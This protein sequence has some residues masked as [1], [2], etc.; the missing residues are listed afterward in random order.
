MLF[1]GNDLTNPSTQLQ[2]CSLEHLF[3][4]I[5]EDKQLE[6]EVAKLRRVLALD[7]S[8]YKRLKTRL[9]Y[10]CGASFEGGNRKI[11][12]FLSIEWFLIDLDH[13][14]R[15]PETMARLQEQLQQD[16]RVALLF[17]SP[18]GGGLKLVFRLDQPCTDTKLFS[19]AYKGFAHALAEEYQL[20][21]YL[22]GRTHDVTR[23]CFLAH[24]P[25]AYHNPLCDQLDWRQYLPIPT[26][27]LELEWEAAEKETLPIHPG[28][29]HS[30][31]PVTYSAI[32]EKLQV[33]ARSNPLRRPVQVPGVLEQMKPLME[34]A[35]L[36][37]GIE[38]EAS[39]PIQH[40]YQL[41]VKS[42]QHTACFNVFFGKKGFS[43]VLTT[44]KKDHPELGE[45][46]RFIAEQ[47]IYQFQEWDLASAQPDEA[48][49]PL[50][51]LP[52]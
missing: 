48:V 9:P 13:L 35:L 12:H 17:T 18:S 34:R 24:D 50:S 23:V 6:Q 14:G 26:R 28:K 43:V 10:F 45:L 20:G 27:A 36:E 31:H 41:E 19:D 15:A 3:H 4:Q 42:G 39:N 38:L 16:E 29:S 46:V 8:S 7:P 5:R 25:K 11:N 47:A 2:P 30:I 22:D 44:R 21:E 37:Q 40:G 49:L 52:Y 32:L 33:K 1:F 51:N